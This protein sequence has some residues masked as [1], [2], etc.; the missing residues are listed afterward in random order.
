MS[1]LD[2]VGWVN[3]LQFEAEAEGCHGHELCV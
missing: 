1:T 3:I 2:G